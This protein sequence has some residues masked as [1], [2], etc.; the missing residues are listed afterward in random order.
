MAQSPSF[1]E[2]LSVLLLYL[3]GTLTSCKTGKID[4]DPQNLFLIYLAYQDSLEDD[5]KTNNLKYDKN[6][7]PYLIH[8]ENCEEFKFS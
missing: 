4:E 2:N 7:N 3:Y 5:K 6:T 8:F 1:F